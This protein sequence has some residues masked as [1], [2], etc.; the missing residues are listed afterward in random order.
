M[1]GEMTDRL[2][3]C[4]AHAL[5]PTDLHHL[6]LVGEV[7]QVMLGEHDLVIHVEFKEV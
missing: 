4:H 7:A 2:L 3:V 5:A 6:L 1:R